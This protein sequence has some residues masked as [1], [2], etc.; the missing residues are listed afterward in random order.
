MSLY[1]KE[2]FCPEQCGVCCAW[3]YVGIVQMQKTIMYIVNFPLNLMR[4]TIPDIICTKCC[5][6]MVFLFKM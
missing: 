3:L 2:Y 6:F 1:K 4:K 5:G